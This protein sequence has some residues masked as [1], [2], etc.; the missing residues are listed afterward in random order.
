[1]VEHRCLGT[2][3][4]ERA[5]AHPD[6]P[7]VSFARAEDQALTYEQGW[8][9]AARWARLFTQSGGRPGDPV[10]IPMSNDRNFVGAFFGAAAAGLVPAPS[11]PRRGLDQATFDGFLQRRAQ[12]IRARIV[13][14]GQDAEAGGLHGLEAVGEADLPADDT[15]FLP[16]VARTAPGLLQFTSGTSGVA[17]AVQL[18]SEALLYQAEALATALR[19]DPAGDLA[20]SWLPLFHDMGL[21]GFLLAPL[22]AGV[23]TVLIKTETFASRPLVWFD[24]LSRVGGTITAGP[25]SAYAI[26]ARLAQSRGGANLDLR[27]VRVALVGA[28]P[29]PADRLRSSLA[30]LKR[31]GLSPASFLPAYGLAEVGVAATL[32]PVGREPEVRCRPQLTAHPRAAHEVVSC[33]RP[34][35]GTEVKILSADDTPAGDGELGQIAIRSP[36]V[37][38]CYRTQGGVSP[39]KRAGEWLLTG[40]EGF[41]EDGE[42]FVLGRMDEVI[43]VAGEKYA[44]EEFEDVAIAAGGSDVRGAIAVALPDRN[45][46]TNTVRLLIETAADATL[47][48]AI[49]MGIRQALA[50]R[51]LPVA[52]IS[53]VPVKSVRRTANG[54]IP[55][56]AHRAD[57]VREQ[58]HGA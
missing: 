43:A 39:L 5:Q 48:D 47:H 49:S 55:R 4:Y 8:R 57:L 1:M 30:G 14:L 18:S 13:A 32:S 23:P 34:I 40:D 16:V 26:A 28:E 44:P 38:D 33:G 58:A 56:S 20:V 42:L 7:F 50:Q 29:I 10:L 41:L 11:P 3:L 22:A 37:A 52:T 15:P 17:K 19:A 51:S 21:F 53:F 45:L 25:P 9:L 36:S 27:R 31:A 35:P 46:G 24:T 2:L 6:R 54:K 12:T